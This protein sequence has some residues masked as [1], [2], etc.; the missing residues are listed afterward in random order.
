[1]TFDEATNEFEILI[2]ANEVGNTGAMELFSK[3]AAI[4]CQGF[5]VTFARIEFVQVVNGSRGENLRSLVLGN[6]RNFADRED[7]LTGGVEMFGE[8]ATSASAVLGVFA[9]VFV[10]F[11]TNFAEIPFVE[12]FLSLANSL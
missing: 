8:T 1:M 11:G 9:V 6:F 5:D 12:R 2:V 3:K 4:A 7:E 10:K